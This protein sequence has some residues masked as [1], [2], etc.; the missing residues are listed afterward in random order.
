MV[1]K[2]KVTVTKT[3]PLKKTAKPKIQPTVVKPHIVEEK[4]GDMMGRPVHEPAAPSQKKKSLSRF[5]WWGLL[6][7]LLIVVFIGF[8][9][10]NNSQYFKYNTNR[11]LNTTGLFHLDTGDKAVEPQKEPFVMKLTIIYNKDNA[12]M[13]TSI[14]KY[15]KNIETNLQNTK[16]S[17]VW[18][19]KNDPQAKALITKLDAKY[20]PIFMVDENIK[21]HPQYA[22][23]S[24][25]VLSKNGLYEF[26]AEGME[27]MQKP[28]IGNARYLGAK[29][30]K[31]KVVI[32]EF[33]SF[34]C[35][36]CKAMFP[37]IQSALKK[38]GQDISLVVKHF[39][40]GGID[41]VLGQAVECAADQGKLEPMM[42]N[43][44]L[45]E[46]DFYSAMQKTDPETAVYDQIGVA[47]KAAGANS[48]KVVSCVKSGKYADVIT[49]DTNE[50]ID[51]GISGT[52]SFFFND[53][54]VGGALDATQ[55]NQTI[56][57]QLKK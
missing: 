25:A 40:R 39:N 1:I 5:P 56:D 3:S 12:D 16:V 20:L 33:A 2:K 47:A 42:A 18:L 51:F 8:L 7:L 4:I 23:F 55:F 34:S 19:D 44:Y 14:D 38:Y 29:P 50:G 43:M 26:A 45:K 57:E 36:Y 27:Y 41:I 22:L 17:A 15:L 53:K 48:D 52:P 37:I 32:M 24:N 11:L 30:D 54:F 9:L 6:S 31:A 49:K 35:G 46:A 13:K 21:Q 28:E 10:Y